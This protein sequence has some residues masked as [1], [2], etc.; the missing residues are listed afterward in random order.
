MSVAEQPLD[1]HLALWKT[2]F[3]G[4]AY[5]DDWL[6]I[7]RGLTIGRILK[8]SGVACGHPDW[9]WGVDFDRRPQAAD[10]RGVGRDFNEC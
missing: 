4:I 10:M 8:Q 7:W 3:D 2:T 9:W 5:D 6:V 1:D